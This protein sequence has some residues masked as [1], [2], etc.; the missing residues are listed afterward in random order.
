[1]KRSLYLKMKKKRKNKKNLRKV[2]YNDKC[3]KRLS[4][5]IS[6]PEKKQ[7]TVLVIKPDAVRAGQTESIIES[8]CT[9]THLLSYHFDSIVVKRERI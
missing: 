6:E 5:F 1:M 9:H 4:S 7:V 8:V 3:V 2:Q